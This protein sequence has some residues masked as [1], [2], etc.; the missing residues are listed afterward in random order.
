MRKRELKSDS[1]WKMQELDYA[2]RD[3]TH[4]YTL[5]LNHIVN[6]SL[7]VSGVPWVATAHYDDI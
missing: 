5:K 4:W 6:P 2:S 1:F 7:W 3:S